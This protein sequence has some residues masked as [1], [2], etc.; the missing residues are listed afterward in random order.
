MAFDSG[1]RVIPGALCSGAAGAPG[2]GSCVVTV[3][4]AT[5]KQ[6]VAWRAGSM[7]RWKMDEGAAEAWFF[8]EKFV[9][10]ILHVEIPHEAKACFR[11]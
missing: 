4:I 3:A 11:G 8:T 6:V 2:S 1:L 10:C 9:F 5:D 7:L